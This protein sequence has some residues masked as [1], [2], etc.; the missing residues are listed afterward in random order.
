VKRG[1]AETRALKL[2][3]GYAQPRSRAA[4]DRAM[5]ELQEKFLA[6]KVEERY[7][8]FTYVWDTMDHR[9]PDAMREARDLTVREA[10]Y[11][12]VRRYLEVAGFASEKSVARLLAISPSL[13]TSATQRLEQERIIKRA[14][15]I[16]SYPGEVCLLREY[17][18]SA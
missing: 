13:V 4:F 7:E 18:P 5:K 16:D 11:R 3:S 15:R 10:A 6:L 8:P 12:V 1:A 9:W 17:A 14:T 2:S